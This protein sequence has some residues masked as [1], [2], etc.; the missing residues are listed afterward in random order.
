MVANPF[1]FSKIKVKYSR[2]FKIIAVILVLLLVVILFLFIWAGVAGIADIDYDISAEEQI[3]IDTVLAQIT[4]E[5][6]RE[7]AIALLGPPDRDLF[8]KVNW[9]VSVYGR[10]SRVGV[11]FSTAGKANEVVLDGGA[12]RFYYR[13]SLE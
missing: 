3:Y 1:F 7:E 12:G 10:S 13:K 8:L 2:F 9:W 4:A 6:T 5:T 11:Y